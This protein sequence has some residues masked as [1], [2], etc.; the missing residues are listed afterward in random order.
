M[1][2][3]TRKSEAPGAGWAGARW[4][5]ACFARQV[6]AHSPWALSHGVSAADDRIYGLRIQQPVQ[7]L[8]R[9]GAPPR[10]GLRQGARPD[11]GNNRPESSGRYHAVQRKRQHHDKGTQQQGGG[12]FLKACKR[13]SPSGRL[14]DSKWK[15]GL[16]SLPPEPRRRPTRQI[17]GTNQRF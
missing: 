11:G 1:H 15:S 3:K 6:P 8:R 5:S 17:S 4:T 13:H 10:A 7:L 14:C 12:R 2:R 16:G 9:A